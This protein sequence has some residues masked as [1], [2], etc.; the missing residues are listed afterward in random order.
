MTDEADR[1][2][3][4]SG[5][6]VVGDVSKAPFL[7]LRVDRVGEPVAHVW[8]VTALSG[9]GIKMKVMHSTFC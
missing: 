5:T 7:R 1:R 3:G 8:F 9:N 2:F 4:R 6:S